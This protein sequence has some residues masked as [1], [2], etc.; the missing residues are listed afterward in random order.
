MGQSFIT[1]AVLRAGV[2]AWTTL[3]ETKG[4]WVR[5]ESREETWT[6]PEEGEAEA[7]QHSAVK[8]LAHRLHGDLCLAVPAHKAL[9]RVTDLPSVDPDEIAGMV[10]LQVDKFSPFPIEQMAVSYETLSQTE[11]SSR[12]L[13]AAVQREVVEGA[14]ASFVKAGR[15]PHRIDLDV[16]GWWR[17]IHEHDQPTEPEHRVLLILDRN[18]TQLVVIHEGVPAVIR[19]LGVS[20]DGDAVTAEM[21]EEVEYTLTSL[22]AEWGMTGLPWITVWKWNDL[23]AEQLA[24]RL[25]AQCDVEVSFKALD[26]LPPLTEGL[27][28]RSLP[29]DTPALNFVSAEWKAAETLR[30]LRKRY[31]IAS[32]VAL[33]VWM[34]ALSAFLIGLQTEQ[35]RL[36]EMKNT[37]RRL[38]EPAEAVRAMQEK[39]V[40]FEQFADRTHSALE[41]LRE[42]SLLLPQGVDLLSFTYKKGAS[43]VLRGDAEITDPV[44][45]FFQALEQSS[46][47]EKV[48]AAPITN[49]REGNRDIVQFAVT[50]TLPGEDRSE[51]ETV[52]P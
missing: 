23:P 40:S 3:K 49:R 14:G 24:A 31:T 20:D 38:E 26:D 47:F 12:V 37:L 43:L 50:L 52:E 5:A 35:G 19:S 7:A 45:D 30:M 42:V 17:L 6:L 1:G 16:M 44:Y 34:T 51:G 32:A 27:A 13:I 29:A 10:E 9:V 8:R 41:G 11:T 4:A 39:V 25:R 28:W 18:D 21:A 15:V 46:L 36:R 22:E 2:L 48:E 33:A